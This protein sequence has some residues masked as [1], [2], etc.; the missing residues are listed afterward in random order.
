MPKKGKRNKAENEREKSPEFKHYKRKHSA[1]ES[2]INALEIH[3][4]DRC[5]DKGLAGFERYVSLAIVARNVQ[6]I[7]AEL[8]RM[9]LAKEQRK[10][11]GKRMQLQQAA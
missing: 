8:Q 10:N 9:A 1:V 5:P 4:L 6:K 2:A 3:G 11:Q 7:G